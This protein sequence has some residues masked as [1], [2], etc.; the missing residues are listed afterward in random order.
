MISLAAGSSWTR[1]SS[2][3]PRFGPRGVRSKFSPRTPGVIPAR[4]EGSP[5]WC[6]SGA[7]P[8]PPCSGGLQRG[9]GVPGHHRPHQRRGVRRRLRERQPDSPGLTVWQQVDAPAP[10]VNRRGDYLFV[11]PGVEVPGSVL[12]SRVVLNA[13]RRL[14]DGTTLWTSDHYRVLAELEAFSRT[15]NDLADTR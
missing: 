5:S 4:Y 1:G 12:W 15:P 6:A 14:P 11:I 3:L 7:G 13:P 10:T 2:S 8:C 9:R